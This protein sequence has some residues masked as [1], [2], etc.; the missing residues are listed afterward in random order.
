MVP[1]SSVSVVLRSTDSGIHPED[2][3]RVTL[4]GTSVRRVSSRRT[5]REREFPPP[6]SL[7]PHDDASHRWTRRSVATTT[8]QRRLR[9]RGGGAVGGQPSGS[10]GALRRSA[11]SVSA[12]PKAQP[13]T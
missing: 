6:E 3:Y 5:W 4:T 9:R 11:I 8:R 1:G 13:P 12:A 10:T 7:N 2:D